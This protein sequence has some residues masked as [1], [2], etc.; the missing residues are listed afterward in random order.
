M[1]VHGQP[2][3]FPDLGT[4]MYVE[5]KQNNVHNKIIYSSPVYHMQAHGC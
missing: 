2:I 4:Q 1:N 5:T 3:I